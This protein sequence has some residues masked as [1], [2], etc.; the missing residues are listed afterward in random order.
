[1]PPIYNIYDLKIF[2]NF[3]F[4]WLCIINLYKKIDIKKNFCFFES[5]ENFKSSILTDDLH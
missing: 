2:I 3:I 1:L 4:S 5:L